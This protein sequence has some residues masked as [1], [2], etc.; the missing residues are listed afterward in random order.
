MKRS[1]TPRRGNCLTGLVV[2]LAVLGLLLLI[3]GAVAFVS[4]NPSAALKQ[5]QTDVTALADGATAIEAP[6]TVEIDM[7]PGGAAFILS[8]S[9]KVGDKVIPTPPAGVAYTIS[10]I[11]PAGDPVKVEANTAPRNGTE[12]FYFFGFC[13]LKTEG[14]YKITVAASDGSTPAAILA[15]RASPEELKRLVNEGVRASIG[16]LGACGG[17]CGL[18]MFVV[19]GVIALF[20]RKKSQPDPLAM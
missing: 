10:V 11:D 9:G 2:G 20:I 18:A 4:F 5:L 12:P 6:T 15:T 17:I 3:A 1:S 8:P 13:E 16:G 14:V 7:K 19:F